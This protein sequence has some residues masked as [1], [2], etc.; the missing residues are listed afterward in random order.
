MELENSLKYLF[1]TVFLSIFRPVTPEVAGS[2]PVDPATEEATH[3]GG[4]FVHGLL[5]AGFPS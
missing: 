3:S 5:G 4:F 2:S 1:V